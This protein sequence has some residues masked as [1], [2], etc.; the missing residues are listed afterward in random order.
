[1]ALLLNLKKV[2]LEKYHSNIAEM[3][4]KIE[5][6]LDNNDF[7]CHT[8]SNDREPVFTVE[9]LSSDTYQIIA[10]HQN[11]PNNIRMLLTESF[12]IKCQRFK[13]CSI[14]SR[15]NTQVKRFRCDCKVRKCHYVMIGTFQE[16]ASVSGLSVM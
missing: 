13:N 9:T 4:S 10:T 11:D 1:M 5:V 12:D 15:H 3:T 2:H 6:L 8:I 7:T 16:D 14:I